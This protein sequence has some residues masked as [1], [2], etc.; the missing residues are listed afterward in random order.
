MTKEELERRLEEINDAIEQNAAQHNEMIKDR[1]ALISKGIA[2]HNMLIGQRNEV[3]E[4]LSKCEQS[5]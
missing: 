3:T 1:D 5:E 2:T 4:W